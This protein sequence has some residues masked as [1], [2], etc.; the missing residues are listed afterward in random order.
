MLGFVKSLARPEGNITGIANM[1]SDITS[2]R[3]ALLKEVVPSARRFALFMHPDE[4][5]VV[6][7]QLRDIEATAASLGVE[8]RGFPM[9]YLVM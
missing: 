6:S 8:Y 1:A 4:T 2:K 7:L 9:R 3:I 5:P